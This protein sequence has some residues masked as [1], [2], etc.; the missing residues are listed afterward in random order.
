MVSSR[1]LG[2]TI[3]ELKEDWGSYRPTRKGVG[4]DV[5]KEKS[6]EIRLRVCALVWERRKASN[7]KGHWG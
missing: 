6:E 1:D 3:K 4:K 7:L 2:G 5:K